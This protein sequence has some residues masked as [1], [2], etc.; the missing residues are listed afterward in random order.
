MCLFVCTAVPFQVTSAMGSCQGHCSPSGH[1]L[2]PREGWEGHEDGGMEERPFWTCLPPGLDPAPLVFD[3][4]RDNDALRAGTEVGTLVIGVCQFKAQGHQ[5]DKSSGDGDGGQMLVTLRV[6]GYPPTPTEL[7]QYGYRYCLK[8][9]IS[10]L[11]SKPP[12]ILLFKLY[13]SVETTE[14]YIFCP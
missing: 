6:D 3:S 5:A 14:S 9:R 4:P 10:H 2:Y 13:S 11:S 12:F 7:Q 8:V 1:L